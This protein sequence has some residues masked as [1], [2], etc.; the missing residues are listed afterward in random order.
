LRQLQASKQFAEIISTVDG[1]Q[2]DANDEQYANAEHPSVETRDPASN[3]TWE[4]VEHS[5][6]HIPEIVSID[7]GMQID[8][9]DGISKPDWGRGGRTGPRTCRPSTQI[10]PLGKSY[11]PSNEYGAIVDLESCDMSLKLRLSY[12]PS[13]IAIDR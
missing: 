1:M 7:D 2:T 13:A 6:K 5:I 10:Q 8:V 4:S 11:S 3:V 12:E 9:S